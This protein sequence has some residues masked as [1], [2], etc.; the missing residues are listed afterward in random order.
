MISVGACA[1]IAC[2]WEVTALKPGNVY[3]GADFDDLTYADFL[4]SAAVV[5]PI[6]ERT[7]DEG[8]GATVRTAVAATRSAVDTNTNLGMLL[9]LTP[10]AAVPRNQ[11]L[12]SG[13]EEVLQSLTP[14]DTREVYA[15]IRLAQPGGLGQ[16]EKA[17]VRDAEPPAIPLREAMRLAANR[18]LVAQQYVNGF[19]QVFDVASKIDR[20]LQGSLPLGEAIVHGYLQ[21]LAEIPDSL[22]ARKC[23]KELAKEASDRAAAVLHSGDPGSD[24]YEAALAEIDFWLRS[25]G[26]RRNPGTT[27]DLVTAALFVLVRDQR[28][29]WPVRFYR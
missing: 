9:L 12:P 26:H 13:I 28:L 5:G 4:T 7:L 6:L 14:E 15:A 22:I 10:L 25:D 3:R 16:V 18:D 21:L 1:T 29:H 17:D 8:V 23:G 19:E 24:N 20:C 27:A 11:S 2:L